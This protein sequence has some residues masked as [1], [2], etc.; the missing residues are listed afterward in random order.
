MVYGE[1]RLG[2]VVEEAWLCGLG[3]FGMHELH[4]GVGARG[5]SWC[6]CYGR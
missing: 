5:N 4:T 2:K 6:F 3:H 1:G